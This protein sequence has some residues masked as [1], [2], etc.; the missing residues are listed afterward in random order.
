MNDKRE[1]ATFFMVY[2]LNM[3]CRY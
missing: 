2:F 1:R 3:L